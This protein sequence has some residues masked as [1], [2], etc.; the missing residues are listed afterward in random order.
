MLLKRR[1][2]KTTEKKQKKKGF[3]LGERSPPM[4]V[5][6]NAILS[7]GNCFEIRC[8]KVEKVALPLMICLDITM[9]KILFSSFL[10]SDFWF[11]FSGNCCSSWEASTWLGKN[12]KRASVTL[13]DWKLFTPNWIRRPHKPCFSLAAHELFIFAS[14]HCGC[15]AVCLSHRNMF[16]WLQCSLGPSKSHHWLHYQGPGPATL[17]SYTIFSIKVLLL[18]RET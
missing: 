3:V 11:W 16:R 15:E 1:W 13:L 8:K 9:N 4:W 6:C 7:F 10:S 5:K 12:L 14:F 17:I 18:L 2:L